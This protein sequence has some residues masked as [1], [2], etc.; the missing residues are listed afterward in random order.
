MIPIETERLTLRA[1]RIEDVEALFALD[2]DPLVQEF[3]GEDPPTR[4][5]IRQWIEHMNQRFPTGSNRG[6][7]AAEESGTFIGWFHLRPSHDTGQTELGYRLA[8]KAW[9]RGLATEGSRA[10]LGLARR[11]TVIARTMMVNLR[12]RRVMEKL[13][14][15]VVRTFPYSG[16]GPDDEVEYS[17]C[18]P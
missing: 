4:E 17:A 11:E 14:M 16:E 2:S 18:V 3:L 8:T 10:L 15:T 13:G 12:S 6:F 9:G 1:L 7:W 5:G